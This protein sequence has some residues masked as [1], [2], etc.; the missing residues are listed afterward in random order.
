MTNSQTD[1]V[2][3][4]NK[5][6]KSRKLQFKKKERESDKERE[7]ESLISVQREGER[8]LCTHSQ[9]KANPKK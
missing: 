2:K 5:V 4:S 8:E 6:I 7:R 1:K 9:S 3:M